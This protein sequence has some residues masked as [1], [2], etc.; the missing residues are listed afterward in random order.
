LASLPQNPEVSARHSPPLKL[1]LR[2]CRVGSHSSLVSP[3]KIRP[4]FRQNSPVEPIGLAHNRHDCGRFQEYY[5]GLCVMKGTRR[6][7]VANNQ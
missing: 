5:F 6:D 4:I 1:F 3:N 2:F 7:L